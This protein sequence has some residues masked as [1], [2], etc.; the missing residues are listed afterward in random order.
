MDSFLYRLTLQPL[1][2]GAMASGISFTVTGLL[3]YLCINSFGF[4]EG[5]G[6]FALQAIFVA[7]S[8]GIT[9]FFALYLAGG[10]SVIETMSNYVGTF[11]IDH[12]RPGKKIPFF[13]LRI[14][15]LS[16][17]IIAVG[18]CYYTYRA[19]PSVITEYTTLFAKEGLT[20][21]DAMLLYVKVF[22]TFFIAPI[23]AITF[24][25]QYKNVYYF[26]L[27]GRCHCCHAAFSLSYVRS[28]GTETRHYSDIDRKE[29]QVAIGERYEITTED[30]VEVSRRKVDTIYRTEYDYYRTDTTTIEYKKICRC[31][32][33]GEANSKSD[34][35]TESTT[36]KID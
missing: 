29:R 36:T 5:D 4:L 18:L 28:G 16:H 26:S 35:Y 21:T 1:W 23:F 33:C 10:H 34:V 11:W 24:F 17:I 30:D 15:M 8:A 7:V 13:L 12:A 27:D 25:L 6:D 22:F 32:V 2:K 9:C 20:V 14:L 19:Y 3:Y 31:G